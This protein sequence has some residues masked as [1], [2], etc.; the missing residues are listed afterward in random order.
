MRTYLDFEKP[1][2]D[3]EGKVAEL[4]LLGEGEEGV[5]LDEEVRKLEEKAAS[6]L[7]EIYANLNPWQETMVARHPSRPHF[8]DYVSQL[9]EEFTSLAGDR[10]YAEDEALVGGLA[11]FRGQ[12]V[13]VMGHEKGSDTEARLRHN[14]GMARPEGYRKAVRLMEM[15]D[16]FD[17]P[18]ISFIDTAGAYPGIGAEE[19]GQSEAIARSTDCC[20]S[21]KVPHISVIIGEGGSGG[22]V[23]IAT[24]N[25]VMML[26][27]SI[28]SVA[29][30]EASASILWR[31]PARAEDA[32][33]AMKVSSNYLKEFGVIDSIIEEPLGGAHREPEQAI[34]ATGNA[35]ADA[36][37]KYSDMSREEILEHRREKFL[38]IGRNL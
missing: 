30:P 36:L 7:T 27:H 18:V 14:F 22:A 1:V 29:S 9:F 17:I 23:A 37:Q 19:R 5:A 2:A 32:A 8:L 38:K 10:K 31:D 34:M 16:K 12:S 15:A 13:L 26:K 11:R 25:E 28:Y 35:I 3:I 20:L 24:A 33:T 4:K 6:R 21:L